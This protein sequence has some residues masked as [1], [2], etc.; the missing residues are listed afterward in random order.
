MTSNSPGLCAVTGAT[1]YVG[2]RLQHFLDQ[3]GWQTVSWSRRPKTG[4]HHIVFNLGDTV[5]PREF[6]GTRALVHCAYDFGPR[7]WKDIHAVN[8]SGSE[9]LFRAARTAGVE[10][11][12]FISSIS[13]FEGCRSLYGRAKLEI[14]KAARAAG[15]V[16]VRPGLVY[17]A[18]PGGVFGGLVRQVRRGRI[19]PLIGGGRQRQYLVHEDD[20][21]RLVRRSILGEIDPGAGPITLAHDR[22]WTLRELLQTIAGALGKRPVFVP[23][24]WLLVWLALKGLEAAGLPAPFRSDSL[25]GMVYQNRSPSFETAHRLGIACRPLQLTDTMLA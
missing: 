10:R 22:G 25:I 19:I 12:V 1:G 5:D 24:P 14:E 23:A 18:H 6:E 8:V 3:S 17:G 16:I 11:M 21:G 13:A 20:L 15:A 2:S 4:T 9:Q 7:R